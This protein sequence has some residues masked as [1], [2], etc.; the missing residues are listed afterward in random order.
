MYVEKYVINMV[1]MI[2]VISCSHMK[3]W[4]DLNLIGKVIQFFWYVMMQLLIT[5]IHLLLFCWYNHDI[6]CI[7][8]GK[9]AKGT[10]FYITDYINKMDTKTYEMLSL[11]SKVIAQKPKQNEINNQ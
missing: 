3:L 1:M 8:S 11:M 9:A 4:I 10:M 7:L 5:L 2:N 6:K